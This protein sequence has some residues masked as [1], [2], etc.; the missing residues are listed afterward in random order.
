MIDTDFPVEDKF[1]HL[2]PPSDEK[3]RQRGV[4]AFLTVQEG[5][6]K[7]CSFCVVPYTR[8]AETS[9]D[10]RKIVAEAEA[11]GPR[12]RARNHLCSGRTSMPITA[13]AKTEQTGRW[14]RLIVRLAADRG[15]R[16]PALHHQPS[17][18]HDG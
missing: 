10:A 11:S 13:Q 12:R 7:F 2:T 5:C 14:P 1:D 15:R 17:Q 3:I 18:R 8:G 16:A 6:D 9:R 4:S